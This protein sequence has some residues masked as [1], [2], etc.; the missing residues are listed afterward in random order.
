MRIVLI[1]GLMELEVIFYKPHLLTK[2]TLLILMGGN[3]II[4]DLLIE[5]VRVFKENKSITPE[6]FYPRNTDALKIRKNWCIYRNTGA[7]LKRY[8]GIHFSCDGLDS[9]YRNAPRPH[10]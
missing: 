6:C 3:S 5:T 7:R 4:D 2:K 9:Y 1:F 8:R 10:V